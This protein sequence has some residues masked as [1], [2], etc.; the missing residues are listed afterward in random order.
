[1]PETL[2]GVNGEIIRWA[3]EFYNMSPEEAAKAIG[4]DIS[5]Y[6]NWEAGIEHPTY[7]KLKRISALF[8]KPSAVFFFPEPPQ[9]PTIKGD[10]RTLPDEIVNAFSKNVRWKRRYCGKIKTGF[11][12]T[13]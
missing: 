13:S 9:L 4:V 3:R 6:I 8:R 5:H 12:A 11:C 7:A 1:M 2:S 10:L